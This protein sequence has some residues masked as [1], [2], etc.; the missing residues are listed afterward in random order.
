MLNRENLLR[1]Y[2]LYKH[3]AESAFNNNDLEKSL[4]LSSYCA[5]IAWMYP[6]LF[7]F[8][9]D[10]L[11]ILL[12]RTAGKIITAGRERVATEET[13]KKVVL[14]AG[15]LID[16]GALT[17]QYLH[18]FIENKI[19]VL[20]IV[21]SDRNITYAKKTIE[22]IESSIGVEIYIPTSATYSSKIRDI[23]SRILEFN[24]DQAFLHFLPNDI[25]GYCVF[26]QIKDIKRFYIVHNDHTFWL[27]KRCADYF[28]EFRKFGCLLSFQ[29]RQIPAEKIRLLPFYP[30]NSKA[31]FQGLPFDRKDKVVG[32]TGANLYKYLMDPELKYFHAI[33]KLLLQNENFIFCL[34]GYGD[35]VERILEI[36]RDEKTKDR[37]FFLGRRDDF[38]ALVGNVDI[39]FESFPLKGGLTVLAAIEQRTALVGIGNPKSASG[40]IQDFFD[41]KEYQEPVDL[42][43]F[44]EEADLLIKDSNVREEKALR[45]VEHKFNKQDFDS[46]LRDVI[47]GQWNNAIPDINQTLKL[48]DDY[49]LNEYLKLPTSKTSLLTEKLFFLKRS[50]SLKER[51]VNGINLYVER[52]CSYKFKDFARLA[53]LVV[54]GR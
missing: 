1:E 2:N 53:V 7:Q 49:Y 18:F 9:D 37:F 42:D 24:P 12:E 54:V 29:R 44:L 25:I 22:L 36:F 52:S 11:E 35:G 27:G 21:P 33:K 19:E 17:E 39:L 5:Y 4:K 14:Y 41:I 13:P 40:C 48:D 47:R 51:L 28:L 38:Y 50:L 31:E 43:T 45:F 16:S 32:M 23:Y 46:E 30:I 3:R 6:I 10:E 15:Q 8:I 26:S 20:V 34:C